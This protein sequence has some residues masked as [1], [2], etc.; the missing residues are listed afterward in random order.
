M[1]NIGLIGYYNHNNSGDDKILSCIMK[2]FC[3]HN[4]SVVG[5]YEEAYQKI[6]MLNSC[7]FVLFGG[8]GLVCPNSNYA[9]QLFRNITTRFG[10]IGLGIEFRDETNEELIVSI[11]DKAEFVWVR[12][13]ESSDLLNCHTILGNDIT[14]YDPL[15]IAEPQENDVC[16]VNLRPW[17]VDWDIS[18]CKDI[19]KKHFKELIALPF[20]C[21]DNDTQCD[22]E[23]LL[24]IPI[25]EGISLDEAYTRCQFIVGMR[26]H[27][28]VYAVQS[29]IPFLSLPY[30]PKNY[31]LCSDLGLTEYLVELG[32]I[33]ILGDKIDAMRSD[34]GNIRDDL[35]NYRSIAICDTKN[36]VLDVKARMGL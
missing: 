34:Y 29:G 4:I 16:G 9:A 2:I 25:A 17:D 20:H 3:G 6:D 18:L 5:S 1:M 35:I 10:C 14:F 7:D 11:E 12:D 22:T 27:S 15:P 13:S 36:A 33:E 23:S 32:N 8:G 30:W 28:I 21:G 26:F 24:G 31:R 19:L